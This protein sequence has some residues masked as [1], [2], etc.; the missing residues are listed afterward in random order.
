MSW[1]NKVH[2]KM[3]KQKQIDSLARQ[4]KDK[5]LKDDELNRRVNEHNQNIRKEIED[6][7]TVVCAETFYSAVAV[8]LHRKHRF[9]KKRILELFKDIDDLLGSGEDV[10]MLCDEEAGIVVK[11]K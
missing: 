10:T 2:A 1:A 5:L 3:Q 9:G 4:V 7:N 6:E 8:I 11:I